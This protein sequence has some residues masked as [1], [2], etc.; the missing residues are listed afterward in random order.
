MIPVISFIHLWH[1]WFNFIE[2]CPKVCQDRRIYAYTP[3]ASHD[4]SSWNTGTEH[5]TYHSPTLHVRLIPYFTRRCQVQGLKSDCRVKKSSEIFSKSREIGFQISC[6]GR[7]ISYECP[8]SNI[9]PSL[10]IGTP[11]HVRSIAD[12]Q[13]WMNPDSEAKLTA[14]LF[15][16]DMSPPRP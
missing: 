11:T 9:C 8:D 16:L 5:L 2:L 3:L 7:I 4:P 15:Y 10:V 14:I 6:R 12:C 1:K 13:C